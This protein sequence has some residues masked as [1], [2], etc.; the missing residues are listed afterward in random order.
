MTPREFRRARENLGI[1]Q[2]E[3]ATA[4]G[5]S[6]RTIA[7]YERGERWDNGRPVVVPLVVELALSTLT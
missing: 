1:T 3:L 6:V 2:A 5:L 4:L 7:Q